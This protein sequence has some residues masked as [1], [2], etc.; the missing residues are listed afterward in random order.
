MSLLYKPLETI[1]SADLKGLIDNGVR[2][3]LYIEYKTEVFDKRDAKKR[4]QFLGSISGFANASG[5]D[6]LIGVEAQDGVPVA[7]PGI[8]DAVF[9]QEKLRILAVVGSSIQPSML[10]DLHEVPVSEG[11]RVLVIRIPRSWNPPHGIGNDGHYHFYQRHSAGRSPMTLDELRMS[12]TLAAGVPERMRQF[13]AS[14][15]AWLK[16]PRSPGYWQKPA[17]VMHILPFSGMMGM[18]TANF[19]NK[20]AMWL[21]SPISN[22]DPNMQQDG[23]VRRYNAD[24]PLL[25][26]AGG[27]NWHTQLFRN[28]ALEHAGAE[29]YISAEGSGV[30]LAWT[31]QTTLVN[32][33]PRYIRAL[34]TFG[35]TPPMLIVSSLINVPGV[36]LGQGEGRNYHPLSREGIDRENVLLPEILFT[37]TGDEPPAKLLKPMFDGLWN[38]AG[39]DRCPYYGKDGQ[40]DIDENWLDDPDRPY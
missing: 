36:K 21:L 30:V 20:H 16:E 35:V 39:L 19:S 9:E 24:G 10:K 1:T 3:S 40:W 28:G 7:L 22:R 17:F 26:P 5:G 13:H 14:R 6:L 31:L 27:D 8:D 11:R 25:T 32:I 38:A 4:M 15:I 23:G 18:A 12:F 2:E 33:I 37:G 34:A 29:P